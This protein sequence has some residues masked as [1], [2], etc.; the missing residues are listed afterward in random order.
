M[1]SKGR[2]YY[3]AWCGGPPLRGEP[4]TP[5]FVASYNE[6]VANARAPDQSRFRALIIGY[7]ANDYGGL[8]DSTRAQW[9]PWL[10]RIDAHFGLLSI[11]QFDRPQ[12]IR[13]IICNWRS[14]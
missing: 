1:R 13:Q 6:A 14:R 2:T 9:A 7:K 12:K 5:E 8:A 4:G 10:D 3:Y 11:A